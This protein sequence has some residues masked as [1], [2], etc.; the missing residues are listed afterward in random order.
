MRVFYHG[1]CHPVLAMCWGRGLCDTCVCR[2]RG[3]APVQFSSPW[4]INLG[5]GFCC[6][7]C[8]WLLFWFGFVFCFLF[9]D[10]VF[11]TRVVGYADQPGSSRE[12]PPQHWGYSV[13]PLNQLFHM[14]PGMLPTEY[15][16]SLKGK[17]LKDFRRQS[18]QDSQSQTTHG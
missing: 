15:R 16:H 7:C 17:Y 10:S 11:F 18:V 5:F 3:Q 13:H 8:C 12:P 2:H 9:K 14:F 6:S 1:H 4:A